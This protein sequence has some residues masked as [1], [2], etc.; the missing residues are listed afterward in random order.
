MT[1]IFLITLNR[2][3]RCSIFSVAVLHLII[4]SPVNPILSWLNIVCIILIT[5]F[6]SYYSCTFCPVFSLLMNL[7][8]K[9][10]SF[11]RPILV[12]MAAATSMFNTKT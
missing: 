1:A 5:Y 9:K 7:R 3:L 4:K 11:R 8:K 6:I 10:Y 2:N 12:H